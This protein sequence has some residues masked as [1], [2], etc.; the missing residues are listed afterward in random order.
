MIKP[1]YEL[2]FLRLLIQE[3]NIHTVSDTKSGNRAFCTD[4]YILQGISI[5]R[6]LYN[7]KNFKKCKCIVVE[8]IF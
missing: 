6:E 7:N 8:E 4:N 2:I 1:S 3:N 5:A